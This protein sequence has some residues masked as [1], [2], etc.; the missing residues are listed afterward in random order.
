MR[1]SM[2]A[3]FRINLEHTPLLRLV[4]AGPPER[5]FSLPKQ[6]FITDTDV[7]AFLAAYFAGKLQVCCWCIDARGPCRRSRIVC[8]RR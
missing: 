6:R 8:V 3:R 4:E 7:T 5:V 1:C 2:L